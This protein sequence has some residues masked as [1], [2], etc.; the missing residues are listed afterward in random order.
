MVAIAHNSDWRDGGR[1]AWSTATSRDGIVV[2][3]TSG[4]N[5]IGARRRIRTIGIGDTTS[6]EGANAQVVY[7]IL[8]NLGT[9]GSREKLSGKSDPFIGPQNETTSTGID[10]VITGVDGSTKMDLAQGG[11]SL[12]V[13]QI[14]D[15]EGTGVFAAVAT[16][17]VDGGAAQT[18]SDRM[19]VHGIAVAPVASRSVSRVTED[20]GIHSCEQGIGLCNLEWGT[21]ETTHEKDHTTTQNIVGNYLGFGEREVAVDLGND[22]QVVGIE[23]GRGNGG[24][25]ESSGDVQS[26][27]GR[28][29]SIPKGFKR[30]SLGKVTHVSEH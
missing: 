21:S 9:T 11:S 29:L 28:H 19:D 25:T 22:D 1:A 16:Q 13:K 7:Q 17:I 2:A 18:S 15:G 4:A 12:F 8:P 10:S 26:G 20:G 30:G 6:I 27:C 5:I 24:S 14:G 3:C 23:Q